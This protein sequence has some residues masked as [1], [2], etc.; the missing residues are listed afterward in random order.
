MSDP[1]A[2]DPSRPLNHQGTFVRSPAN[3]T[4]AHAGRDDAAT[5]MWTILWTWLAAVVAAV[6]ILGLVF[7]YSSGDPALQSGEPAAAGSATG[8]VPSAPLSQPQPGERSP[9]QTTP[10]DDDP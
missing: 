4:A 5:P 2:T 9:A 7:G 10:A 1:R 3:A 6:V 8:L